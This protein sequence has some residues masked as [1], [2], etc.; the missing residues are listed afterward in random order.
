MREMRDLDG[1]DRAGWD[2]WVAKACQAVGVDPSD[3]D[4]VA[5]H[6]LTKQVA[7]RGDRPLAPVSSYILGLA[8][9]RGG[10]VAELIAQIEAT[11]PESEV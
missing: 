10:D 7:R 8:V 5:I 4:I 9:A 2:A 6:A 3:V 11:L 1:E